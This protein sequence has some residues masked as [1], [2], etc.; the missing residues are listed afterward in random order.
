MQNKFQNIK[1]IIF[2]F[3]AVFVVAVSLAAEATPIYIPATFTPVNISD[4]QKYNFKIYLLIKAENK[5]NASKPKFG[6][7]IIK[8]FPLSVREFIF[9]APYFDYLNKTVKEKADLII[10]SLP[11]YRKK[12]AYYV[13]GLVYN[14]VKDNINNSEANEKSV[15]NPHK[16]FLQGAEV[17]NRQAAC[18][19]EKCRAA[20]TLLRYYSIPAMIVMWRDHYIVEYFLKPLDTE[21]K[22][23]WYIMDFKGEYK[24]EDPFIEPVEWQPLNSKELLNEDWQGNEIFIKMKNIKNLYFNDKEDALRRYDSITLSAI[25][26]NPGNSMEN[27]QTK[28]QYYLL[29]I[30]DYEIWMKE[31]SEAEVKFILPFNNIDFFKTMK[32]LVKSENNNLIIKYKRVLHY[33]VP[34]QEGMIHTLPVEFYSN[35]TLATTAN[36]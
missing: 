15:T 24:E 23:K 16:L 6:Y 21:G 22:G 9:S 4:I 1:K 10:S 26:Y 20:V 17:L 12:N 32:F 14:F 11:E 18:L 8:T 3:L 13:S 28:K 35:V 25:D 36:K 30:I 33:V 27:L 34:P 7:R 29:K 2:Y 5:K 31:K 19:L